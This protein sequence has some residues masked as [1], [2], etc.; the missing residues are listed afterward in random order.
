LPTVRGWNDVFVAATVIGKTNGI[1]VSD[2]GVNW[3]PAGGS[4]IDA[5]RALCRSRP[6]GNRL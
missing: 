6:G 3:L 4:V 2:D 1:L 5:E